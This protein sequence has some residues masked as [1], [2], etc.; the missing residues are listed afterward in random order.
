MVDLA[1][2]LAIVRLIARIAV[3]EVDDPMRDIDAVA[4]LEVGVTHE[5]AAEDP[6]VGHR[7]PERGAAD[8]RQAAQ[9]GA[10][11][12]QALAFA[13][14]GGPAEAEGRADGENPGGPGRGGD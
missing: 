7:D 6:G 9:D 3:V 1:G 12:R 14:A 10:A 2:D 5:V 11:D 13:P 8:D 4:G